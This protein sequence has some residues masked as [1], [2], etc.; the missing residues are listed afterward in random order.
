MH[1]AAMAKTAAITLRVPSHVKAALGR[2]ADK[3]HRSLSAE[4]LNLIEECLRFEVTP[5]PG[6]FVGMFSGSRVPTD[7]EIL[8]TRSEL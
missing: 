2:R 1:N 8:E 4:A 5:T 7:D 6:R 3:S